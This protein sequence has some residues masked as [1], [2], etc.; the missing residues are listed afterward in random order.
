MNLV[1][2]NNHNQEVLGSAF[3]DFLG[4]AAG[5]IIKRAGG[6]L[7]GQVHQWTF[8]L[9]G[10]DRVQTWA[11]T[12]ATYVNKVISDNLRQ[13]DLTSEEQG[14]LN[15]WIDRQLNPFLVTLVKE[16]AQAVQLN[17][18]P[19]KLAALNAVLNK[20]AT[21]EEHYS[22]TGETGLSQ[23]ALEQ[24]NYMIAVLLEPIYILVDEALKQINEPLSPVKVTFSPTNYNFQPLFDRTSVTQVQADNYKIGS[25]SSTPVKGGSS[26]PTKGNIPVKGGGV[27]TEIPTKGGTPNAPIFNPFTPVT[28]NKGDKATTTTNP[29][30]TTVDAEVIDPEFIAANPQPKKNNTV[31]KVGLGALGIAAL[32]SLLKG[33]NAKNSKNKKS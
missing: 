30:A 22:N 3:G 26:T 10:A 2:H 17:S 24:R 5:G 14:I 33:S 20:I 11:N 6:W 7:A 8:G 15:R 28:S 1:T 4:N 12:L 19:A 31:V 23:Y 25:G 32:Y 27:V 13:M 21:I 18:N 16:I 29:V 9:I